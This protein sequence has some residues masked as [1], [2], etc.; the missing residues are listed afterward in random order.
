MIIPK[1][2]VGLQS[3]DPKT[4][5]PDELAHFTAICVQLRKRAE[6]YADAMKDLEKTARDIADTAPFLTGVNESKLAYGSF[7]RNPREFMVLPEGGWPVINKYI[8]DRILAGE[9]PNE[10]LSILSHQ[11]LNVDAFATTNDDELPVGIGR[12]KKTFIR[13]TPVKNIAL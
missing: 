1:T 3:I 8:A 5:P 7:K 2:L 10:V 11:R 6:R 13:F 12:D 9:D 4:L